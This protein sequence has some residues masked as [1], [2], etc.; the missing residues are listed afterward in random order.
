M[1][2][3]LSGSGNWVATH[4]R[5]GIVYASVCAVAMLVSGATGYAADSPAAEKRVESL[6]ADLEKAINAF[7]LHQFAQARAYLD[8]LLAKDPTDEE[9]YR[10][11]QA[12]GA[13]IL[14]KMAVYFDQGAHLEG[15]GDKM[16]QRDLGRGA[17]EILVRDRRFTQKEMLDPEK[18]KAIVNQAVHYDSGGEKVLGQ[19]SQ[20]GQFAVPDL[21]LYL[22]ERQSVPLRVNAS[23]ILSSMG[24]V[25]ISPLIEALDTTDSLQ[26]Q[27]IL[28]VLNDIRPVSP[29]VLP[30]VKA[31][32]DD[33]REIQLVRQWA[34]RVLLTVTG[35]DPATL[36]S[37]AEYYYREANR[38]YLGGIDVDEELRYLHRAYWLWNA[39]KQTPEYIEV[40]NF[41][42]PHLRAEE[43]VF[44][45]LALSPDEKRFTILLGS[46]YF[47]MQETTVNLSKAMALESI[48]R[49]DTAKWLEQTKEWRQRMRKNGR[50]AATIGPVSM[51]TVLR[52]AMGDGESEVAVASIRVLERTARW[53]AIR[54]WDA[55]AEGIDAA[56]PVEPV[57]AEDTSLPANVGAEEGTLSTDAVSE[58]VAVPTASPESSDTMAAKEVATTATAEGNGAPAGDAARVDTVNADAAS[59]TEAGTQTA[60]GEALLMSATLEVKHVTVH[61]LV[62]A[63]HF[64][65]KRVR[66]AAA[67]CLARI[68]YPPAGDAY[69]LVKDLLVEGAQEEVSSSV[70]VISNAPKVREAY[71]QLLTPAFVVQTSPN[72]REGLIRAKR[73]PMPDVILLDG[74]IAEFN[75]ISDRLQLMK[76][77]PNS[78]LPLT[79]VA[80]RDQVPFIADAKHFPEDVYKV[81]IRSDKNADDK[82]LFYEMIRMKQLIS[83]KVVIFIVTNENGAERA[84]IK[85][86]FET[87]AQMLEDPT[88]DP[89]AFSQAMRRGGNTGIRSSYINIFLADELSGFDTMQTLQEL[90]ADPRTRQIPICLLTTTLNAGRIQQQFDSIRTQPNSRLSYFPEGQHKDQM[91]AS[92]AKALEENTAHKN[93]YFAQ[94]ALEIARHSAEGLLALDPVAGNLVLDGDMMAALKKVASSRTADQQLRISIANVFGHFGGEASLLTLAHLVEDET[95]L[96][97]RV[98]ALRSLGR[99]DVHNDY[100]DLKCRML[101]DTQ[102]LEIQEEASFSLSAADATPEQRVKLL[103]EERHHD[104]GTLKKAVV[105]DAETS[106]SDA[107]VVDALTPGSTPASVE[108]PDTTWGASETT[109]EEPASSDGGGA[110][111]W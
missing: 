72:G 3:R 49:P 14:G 37:A 107:P 78:P 48:F 50:I 11:R 22:R 52:K 81:E 57:V 102:P 71:E 38:Y 10:L 5:Y 42:L 40:P 60:K 54:G 29:R 74:N 36:P 89:A 45:G 80:S 63:L 51:V 108:T 20:I 15:L 31:I 62:A 98:A 16:M 1:R 23:Y 21:L 41:V 59:D 12:V 110:L 35:Q 97:L 104:M 100:Y 33:P 93:D 6:E 65:D 18:V 77:V 7:E 56:Q 61:P 84:R 90:R 13:E 27:N 25:A 32:Y 94:Q 105:L 47:K 75:Q 70:L 8:A 66:Y 28:S 19:V 92:L 79:I 91:F 69:S 76:L 34:A 46:I 96:A 83:D 86:V 43:S 58:E 30:K 44:D 64:P 99:I 101:E 109:S 55:V 73:F 95:N 53:D 88:Y 68:G 17:L 103:Q 24:T 87:R 39:E 9:A 2:A 67:N 26:K 111:N 85:Q 4:V 82:D 106:G